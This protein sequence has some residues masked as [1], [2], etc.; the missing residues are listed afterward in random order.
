MK[1]I[2][3]YDTETTGV[4][5]KDK[6]VQFAWIFARIIDW[7][8]YEERTI[9]QYIN[10]WRPIPAQSSNV[11]K[12][13]DKDVE[14]HPKI[15]E[16]IKEFVVYHEKADLVVW[17]NISFDERMLKNEVSNCWLKIEL[18]SKTFCTMLKS[19]DICKIPWTRWKY[20]RPK[21]DELYKHF[22]GE[23]FENAHDALFDIKATLKCFLK[24]EK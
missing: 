8:I 15:E 11:H 20:K 22:F 10:P 24:M 16:C 14:K 18:K 21:L 3:V 13:F 17:H 7:K 5:N 9:N 4:W 6:I 23:W 19:V 1:T 2:F 12:I